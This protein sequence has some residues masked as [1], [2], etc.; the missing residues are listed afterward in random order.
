MLNIESPYDPAI[1]LLGILSKI[2]RSKIWTDVYIPVFILA[3]FKRAKKS[4][5]SKCT[6]TGE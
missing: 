1:P 4:E 5:K 3:L 2:I 6:S